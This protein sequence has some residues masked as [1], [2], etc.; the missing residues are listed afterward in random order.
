M[1]IDAPLQGLTQFF[2][3]GLVRAAMGLSELAKSPVQ[4]TA[5]EVTIHPVDETAGSLE[6]VTD[7]VTVRQ[8]FGGPVAGDA[9]V[10]LDPKS[11]A[12][13]RKSLTGETSL[14]LAIDASA[15]EVL[16]E[17]GNTLLNGCLGTFN[18]VLQLPV[19]SSVPHIS[20]EAVGGVLDARRPVREDLHYALLVRVSLKVRNAD[21]HG[22]LILAMS[23]ASL[24][25]LL[26]AIGEW[27]QTSK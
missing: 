26:R 14:P 2:S 23:M 19:S 17:V 15:R 5:T 6:P 22:Y 9:L 13:L 3:L 16:T 12:R 27:E 4:L 11:A 21:V 24:D 25:R 7:V 10:I 8:I 18:T 1:Q 20:L